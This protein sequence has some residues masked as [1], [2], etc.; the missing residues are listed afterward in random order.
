[1]NSQIEAYTQKKGYVYKYFYCLAPAREFLLDS[2]DSELHIFGVDR[3]NEKKNKVMAF[4]VCSYTTMYALSTKFDT[5]YYEW[6]DGTLP[7]KLHLDI[8]CKEEQFEGRTQTEALDHYI[9][10]VVNY[11]NE[12]ILP[13][14]GVKKGRYIVL[15]SEN[16]TGKASAHLIY[17]NVFF[18][19]IYQ[20]K[21]IL[22]AHPTDIIKNGLFDSAIYRQGVFRNY[23]SSKLGKQNKLIYYKSCGYQKP[24]DDE[25]LFLDTLVR[26]VDEDA[27]LAEF[28]TEKKNSKNKKVSAH[29][30]LNDD[31]DTVE[32]LSI[33]QLK[34]YVDLLT[35]S[36]ADNYEKWVKV[37]LILFKYNNTQKGYQLF[38]TFSQLSEKYD[39]NYCKMKWNSYAKKNYERI[40][41]GTLKSYARS[42]NKEAYDKLECEDEKAHYESFDICQQYIM[43][44]TETLPK[45]KHRFDEW[46]RG[47]NKVL[48][49]RSAYNTGKTQTLKH[50]I[51][52][53]EPHSILF[54][55]SRQSLAYNLQGSFEN[56]GVSNY[57]DG[58]YSAD[59]LICSLDSLNKLMKKDLL[60]NK[61]YVPYYDVVVLDEVE[62]IMA[63]FESNTLT[64][65]LNTFL[66]LD[67]ILKKS[68]KIVALDGDF[69]NRSY[70]Y[71]KILNK[72]DF[73]VIVN[74][75]V[76]VVR[77]WIFT[78]DDEGFTERLSNDLKNNK[79]VFLVSMSS[80][81]ALFYHNMFDDK[82]D[83]LLHYSKSNDKLKQK[84]RTVND[85]WNK[86]DLV[87]ITPTVEAG[88]DFNV[89][90]H[91]DQMYVILSTGSTSQRG[92]LQMC[93]RV[94]S[95]KS[96][97]VHVF[98]NSMNYKT[99]ANLYTMDEVNSMFDAELQH[100]E[101]F[102]TDD[103]GDLISKDDEFKTIRKYNYLENMHKNA[104]YFVPYL[105]KLLKDKGQLFESDEN[106]IKRKKKTV[107]N[108]TKQNLLEADDI[109]KSKYL[110]LVRK[111]EKNE[112]SSKEKYAIER[113]LLKKNWKINDDLT[114]KILTKCFRRTHILYNNKALNGE[115]VK[116][117]TSIDDEYTD[118]DVKIKIKKLKYVNELL[119]LFKFKD[120]N[121]EFTG[122]MLSQ[123]QL[124]E[125][126]GK[127]T[128]KSKLFTDKNVQLLFGLKKKTIETSKS[129]LGFVN[130]IFNNYG[131]KIDRKRIKVK[132]KL[133]YNYFIKQ[134]NFNISTDKDD[135]IIEDDT[136]N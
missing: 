135:L 118:I 70:D 7:V 109:N 77:N 4:V 64:N 79:K 71:L 39:E 37:G 119:Q 78:G 87:I 8:D 74:S 62:S 110:E 121:N 16:T 76:P 133:S 24:D 88:V 86:Y 69:N 107:I 19:N 58:D 6:I 100:N 40:T 72:S 63:H 131:V 55:T 52:E 104:F 82:Y 42:D 116:A 2:D 85:L 43:S 13:I 54:V 126:Q 114:E 68:N 49:I 57:L 125:L 23:L 112:A 44:D 1:M 122:N 56:E 117:Y 14:C 90:S 80:E 33:E 106:C 130:S 113:Y 59:R 61:W 9:K 124:S 134:E 51:A 98:L 20:I 96:T 26:N 83:V 11:V 50:L 115:E 84:L 81:K 38:K 53:Y 28:E 94:R 29:T 75:Y 35:V 15:R 30:E 102:V 111:Q 32:N 105:T 66:T 48:A 95:L 18:K 92:L 12:I 25:D 132:S 36:T 127:I 101:Q 129:F 73:T 89:K 91:F 47:E 22:N 103:N 67:A 3:V 41:I 46:Y 123:D 27:K 34:K 10:L 17:T 99:T 65:K 21:N 60:R 93:N 5:N 45:L 136:N 31:V 128:K 97:D 108:I 120:D